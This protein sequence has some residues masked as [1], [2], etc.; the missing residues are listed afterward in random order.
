MG[1]IMERTTNTK[2]TI[3]KMRTRQQ[4]V[5]NASHSPMRRVLILSFGI[6]VLF[7]VF[8]IWTMSL[9]LKMI[10][11]S[12]ESSTPTA[13]EIAN[14]NISHSMEPS[15]KKNNSNSN[16]KKPVAAA[17]TD[18]PEEAIP[19]DTTIAPEEPEVEASSK[20]APEVA[21][22][23][24]NEES[25]ESDPVP[26]RVDEDDKK[27]AE[28]EAAAAILKVQEGAKTRAEKEAKAE[29]EKKE[30]EAA[31]AKTE[32]EAKA[33]KNVEEE[34]A[35][36]AEAAA[37]AEAK[38]KAQEEE[39]AKAKAAAEA[40]AK[41]KSDKEAAAI[42]KAEVEAK[43]AAEAEAKKKADEEAAKAE[44]KAKAAAETE[45]KI[46]AEVSKDI[47]QNDTTAGEEASN[48]KSLTVH[49]YGGSITKGRGLLI[50]GHPFSSLL[51]SMMQEY[52]HT[53]NVVVSNFGI[54]ASG[55]QY[56]IEC[57]IGFADIIISEF[58]INERSTQMLK[59]WYE[60]A[61]S[62]SKHLVVL[63]LWSWLTPPSNSTG[64][65][66]IIALPTI[67]NT[68]F[69]SLDKTEQ[70]TWQDLIPSYFNY[71][72]SLGYG[73]VGEY[74]PQECYDSRYM[75]SENETWQMGRCR[76]KFANAMQHGTQVYHDQVAKTLYNHLVPSVI[77]SILK[78]DGDHI[79]STSSALCIGKWNL[80]KDVDYG[81]VGSW[82]TTIVY[83]E[84]FSVNYAYEPSRKDASKI[85]L[86]TNTTSSQLQLNCPP[87][88]NTAKIGYMAHSDENESGIIV[89]NGAQISTQLEGE[90]RPHIRI[91][92][93]S[94]SL[95]LPIKVSIKELPIGQYIEFTGLV[96]SKK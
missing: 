57:G 80:K 48:Q 50:D 30:E 8:I 40:E 11:R 31:K 69:V 28:E 52:N 81:K 51:Q 91:R 53:M 4:R 29:A 14:Q 75:R 5:R 44:A 47:E 46:E 56:W 78:D 33:K 1:S 68:S 24:T 76:R 22:D 77:T 95:T 2:M 70:D 86:N 82:N 7:C 87:L 88:Y 23:A 45:A 34:E 35:D 19:A 58:R 10:S 59:S 6:I 66:T 3:I 25:P 62:Q 85:T 13:K 20:N 15:M 90:N 43:A 96:C 73:K 65:P 79:D 49:V 36:K 39:A 93:Y 26:V 37:E 92:Q 67:V 18:T 83:N 42:A 72:E 12:N 84:G 17:S 74:I 41:K 38:N 89:I 55:P 32:A 61:Q 21:P 60:L 54:P 9:D 94:S 63:D 64:K 71:S 16:N 27:K